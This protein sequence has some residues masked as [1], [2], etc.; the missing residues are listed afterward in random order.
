MK[1]NGKWY[2]MA[3]CITYILIYA[4]C[5]IAT[6]QFIK[7]IIIR[8]IVLFVCFLVCGYVEEKVLSRFV[9]SFIE[10]LLKEK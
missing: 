3:N 7:N 5:L 10:R 1:D 6:I 8:V 9:N 2:F 4:I